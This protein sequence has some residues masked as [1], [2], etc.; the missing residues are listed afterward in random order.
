[1]RSFGLLLSAVA[2][3]GVA[4]LFFF[5]RP[6]PPGG[7]V[8]RAYSR[9]YAFYLN[10][11]SQDYRRARLELTPLAARLNDSVAYRLDLAL[12]DL[13]E[14]NQPVQDEDRNLGDP[15]TYQ[16]LLE[17]A[18]G[19]LERARALAPDNDAVAYNLARTYQKLAP[20]AENDA[21]L[22]AA[23]A[24][25]L[26]PL[27][28]VEPPDPAALFLVA[29]LKEEARD[30]EGARDSYRRVVDLGKDFVPETQFIVAGKRWANLINRLTGDPAK[31]KEWNE[32]FPETPKATR[33]AL[34]SGRYTKFLPLTEAPLTRPDPREM[35]WRSVTARSL[36]P[37]A[38]VGRFF[39]APDLDNDCRRDMVMDAKDGLRVLR[40]R[41]S[42]SFED[43]TAASGIEAGFR[44]DGAAAGDLDNDGRCDLVVAGPG[45]V[46]VYLNATDP[47]QRTR[48]KFVAGPALDDRAAA[49]VVVWDLDH[50]GDLDI[51]VGGVE[52]RVYRAAIEILPD[53]R[54]LR[55]V[56]IATKLGM[57]KPPVLD[58][59]AIDADDDHDTDLVIGND[60]GTWWCEN[61]RQL[62]FQTAELGPAG[63]LAAGDVDNDGVEELGVGRAVFKWKD[64]G[65]VKLGERDALLDLDGDGV[66]DVRPFD[67]I[68]LRG[69]VTRAV[70]TDLNRDG[71]RDLIVMTLEGLDVYMS[72]PDRPSAWIDF[73]PRGLKANEFGIGAKLQL[74]AGDLRIGANCRD[75][76]VSFGL[77]RRT[78]I[79]AVLLRWTN[80][81]EQGEVGPKMA[82]CITIEE[83]EGEVGS[84]P[85]LYTFANGSWHFIADCHSG[86]P[87]GLPYKDGAY[88]P[89]RSDETILI[90]GERLAPDG[91]VLRLDLAEEFRELFYVDK[92]VLRAIDHPPHVR[93]VLNEGFKVFTHPEFRVFGFTELTPPRRAT[94]QKGRDIT[95]A[96]SR[97]DLQ[98][99]VVFEEIDSRYVGL[100]RKWT[101][102]LD[103][104]DIDTSGKTYLVMDGW[105]E[106]P[107]ASASIAASQTKTVMFMPPVIEAQG[108]DGSWKLVDKDPGFPAGKIKSVLVD[109][110]GKLETGRLRV[111]STQ[112][113]HWDSFFLTT[114]AEGP[115]TLTALPLAS[116]HHGWR[117]VGKRIERDGL[118]WTYSHDDLE[119]FYKWD[120]MPMGMLT[121]YGDVKELLETIDDKYPVLASGDVVRLEFDAAGL[122]ELPAGWVRDWCFTTEGWV[123][124]A[125]MNQAVRERVGPLPFHAMGPAYPYDESKLS[126]PHP[127]W[128]KEWFTRPA[129][130]LVN[131]E[132]L[133]K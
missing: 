101:I 116:A 98:H 57:Q 95:D 96:V 130:R 35:N 111:S 36:L 40:S 73:M 107:T 49:C 97:R 17:S 38:G 48:W 50:D 56:E 15:P 60:S 129:R 41:R 93:P 128:V 89:P 118:P 3:G 5:K 79:D 29:E 54:E 133:G 27:A 7:E 42:G 122:P 32:R 62:E 33:L 110:S 51:F 21:E 115:V 127:E 105:V 109:L 99:A 30:Y 47:E 2:L 26:E 10:E 1:M 63:F 117:G 87:L 22:R 11:T 88:L 13:S 24:R 81:V 14:I 66:L 9:A 102:E 59:L 52:N 18:L 25:L 120:Q 92:V 16:L 12:I 44:L 82:S 39:I 46:R 76:L 75:G 74:M 78:R 70:G 85:F 34:E 112:K 103:F 77:G 72:R 67:G 91:G 69:A 6:E 104:G 108:K 131:P 84:C 37:E 71:G 121:R 23:A 8:G 20:R 86:T 4:V 90:P 132:V 45:G 106:F 100:A 125:D 68:E 83:R 55:Y 43:M 113:L 65:W 58:A 19:H 126:H 123:K 119:T 80:G 61:L 28:A 53:R 124:D 114:G 31:I 94:D 64:K